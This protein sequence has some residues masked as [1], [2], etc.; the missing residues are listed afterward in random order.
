[1]T[2]EEFRIGFSTLVEHYQYIEMHLEG[3]YACISGRSFFD[4]LE[5]VS[6]YSLTKLIRDL[7]EIDSEHRVRALSESDYSRLEALSK[8][9]NFWVHNAFTDLVF[10]VK[11]GGLRN[12]KDIETMESDTQEARF[13]RDYLFATKLKLMECKE[14]SIIDEINK[15]LD[16][17]VVITDVKYFEIKH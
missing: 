7:E 17:P 10:D 4:T 14:E 2:E 3:I 16:V 1:M 12:T 9:R 8:R 6:T 5:D 15:S 11:T 13:M